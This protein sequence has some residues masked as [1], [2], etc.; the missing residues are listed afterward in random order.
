[1]FRKKHKEEREA[2]AQAQSATDRGGESFTMSSS[3]QPPNTRVLIDDDGLDM[4]DYR[5]ASVMTPEPPSEPSETEPS[6]PWKRFFGKHRG[7]SMAR[8]ESSDAIVAAYDMGL[9]LPA[10]ADHQPHLFSSNTHGSPSRRVEEVVFEAGGRGEPSTSPDV[11][12]NPSSPTSLEEQS[13]RIAQTAIIAAETSSEHARPGHH[14]TAASAAT[15]VGPPVLPAVTRQGRG[16]DASGSSLQDILHTV[17]PG[18]EDAKGK[19]KDATAESVPEVPISFEDRRHGR[20]GISSSGRS[21]VSEPVAGHHHHHHHKSSH[22]PSQTTVAEETVLNLPSLSV[23][24]NDVVD[25]VAQMNEQIK[26]SMKILDAAASEDLTTKT[27]EEIFHILRSYRDLVHSQNHILEIYISELSK[28]RGRPNVERELRVLKDRETDVLRTVE[29]MQKQVNAAEESKNQL[30]QQYV[31]LENALKQVRNADAL[32]EMKK[33]RDLSVTDHE[34]DLAKLNAVIQSEHA[35]CVELE[36]EREALKGSLRGLNS[37]QEQLVNVRRPHKKV[38][39]ELTRFRFQESYAKKQVEIELA[40]L[41]RLYAKLA[42]QESSYTAQLAANQRALQTMLDKVKSAEEALAVKE[43]VISSERRKYEKEMETINGQMGNITSEMEAMRV[44]MTDAIGT[45]DSHANDFQSIQL[46][47]KFAQVVNGAEEIRIKYEKLL[48]Q[49]QELEEQKRIQESQQESVLQLQEKL[50]KLEMEKAPL[51]SRL[52]I[53]D[54]R[55][56]SALDEVAVKEAQIVQRDLQIAEFASKRAEELEKLQSLMNERQEYKSKLASYSREVEA[57]HNIIPKAVEES[58][59]G[60]DTGFEKLL[61]HAL[62]DLEKLKEL[63]EQGRSKEL[64][65]LR[66][67]E[68]IKISPTLKPHSSED[69]QPPSGEV[70]RTT[71]GAPPTPP[72]EKKRAAFLTLFSRSPVASP[73]PGETLATSATARIRG[74]TTHG[75]L[76]VGA[77]VAK[78]HRPNNV[79]GAKRPQ[80]NSF[81]H[82]QRDSLDHSRGSSTEMEE[83][84]RGQEQGT[85]RVDLEA[86]EYQERI[87]REPERMVVQHTSQSRHFEGQR[88]SSDADRPYFDSRFSL[89]ALP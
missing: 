23:N 35:Q 36:K 20:H 24:M 32:K 31:A 69:Q 87:E 47:D 73:T 2:D 43:S 17:M 68:D 12:V 77:E 83:R 58:S 57:L 51:S 56:R 39:T 53:M 63:H 14:G 66:R 19:G 42:E 76:E 82:K 54:E 79:K 84:L 3:S 67:L 21:L 40:E 86:F 64:S 81:W 75:V 5:R 34:K 37:L 55:L 59:C 18:Q 48:A 71:V 61:L 46:R 52:S 25:S 13:Q 38:G 85:Y 16:R 45:G 1:M 4:S 6:K 29:V 28:L 10:V 74:D 41:K 33:Q 11:D 78:S 65:I 62:N 50:G 27:P 30:M 22:S 44:R 72:Q 89:T 60:N 8:Q 49:V 9:P 80:S 70:V 7:V 26:V 15:S 88:G